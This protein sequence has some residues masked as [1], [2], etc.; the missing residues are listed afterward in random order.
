VT[1][2]PSGHEF[3]GQSGNLSLNLSYPILVYSCN[4]LTLA[5]KR[6]YNEL[7]KFRETLKIWGLSSCNINKYFGFDFRDSL[8]NYSRGKSCICGAFYTVRMAE[9]NS[10]TFAYLWESV[11][12]IHGED[13][14]IK[15]SVLEACAGTKSPAHLSH[16]YHKQAV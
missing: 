1:D 7:L 12:T 13:V 9:R 2:R 16:F 6:G 8:P 3:P 10:Y 4:E 5:L 11:H 15:S 14:I